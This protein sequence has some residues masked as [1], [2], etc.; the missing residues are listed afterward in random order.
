[1]KVFF[2]TNVLIDVLQKREA[3]YKNSYTV[4][5]AA[6]D[7]SIEGVISATSVTDIFYII[8]KHMDHE[9]SLKII[10]ELLE[11]FTICDVTKDDL[12][13]ALQFKTNDYEDAVQTACAQRTQSNF[14]VT[15]DQKGFSNSPVKAISPVE[16]VQ[17]LQK[18][19]S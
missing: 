5:L 10:M 14:I 6:A 17:I 8:R 11:L 12:F 4:F 1:M 2:D 13:A 7:N 9:S 18:H 16:L 19:K 3:F 15:R